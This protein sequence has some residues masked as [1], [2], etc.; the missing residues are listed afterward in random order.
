MTR[1]SL[2][3]L[4][5]RALGWWDSSIQSIKDDFWENRTNY[6]LE[7]A[8]EE[9]TNQEFADA[10]RKDKELKKSRVRLSCGTAGQPLQFHEICCLLATISSDIIAAS[11]TQKDLNTEHF[12]DVTEWSCHLKALLIK[13]KLW[14]SSQT[15]ECPSRPVCSCILLLSSWDQCAA[16]VRP[17]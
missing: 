17:R 3:K 15:I 1:F 6:I 5:H 7:N 4:G 10:N 2:G 12:C 8:L 14:I 13:S 11:C 16:D 9:L